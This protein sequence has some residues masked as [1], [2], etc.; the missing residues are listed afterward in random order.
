MK[1]LIPLDTSEIA[2]QALPIAAGIANVRKVSEIRLVLVHEPIQ[3]GGYLDAPWNSARFSMERFYIENKARQL[4]SLVA[5]TVIAE[6][7]TGGAV[8]TIVEIA[9][10]TKTNIIV[11]TTHGRTGLSRAWL[12][13]VADGIV[14]SAGAP[15]LMLRPADKPSTPKHD[16]GVFS[17]PLIPLD[18]SSVA[19]SI[20]D[21]AVARGPKRHL[22]T[23]SDRSGGPAPGSWCGFVH[24]HE[25]GAGS[26]G[27]RIRSLG[28]SA[29]HREGC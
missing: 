7:L 12:G 10:S 9:A 1:L 8:E 15:V 24:G 20:L 22:R 29:I 17:R 6:H 2:E 16:A 23:R 14:R 11:M 5:T 26:E 4:R 3:Y 18:G 28:S 21:P 13:S 25:H 27:H 19:E